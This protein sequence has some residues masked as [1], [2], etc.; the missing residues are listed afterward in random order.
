MSSLTLPS[1]PFSDYSASALLV[2]AAPAPVPRVTRGWPEGGPRVAQPARGAA[3]WTPPV[4][5]CPA[6]RHSSTPLQYATPVSSTAANW[7]RSSP[8]GFPSPGTLSRVARFCAYLHLVYGDFVFH[9]WC[10]ILM[11]LD[12]LVTGHYGVVMLPF[13]LCGRGQIRTPPEGR[14]APGN[15]YRTRLVTTVASHVTLLDRHEGAN[16]HL[17]AAVHGAQLPASLAK[18]QP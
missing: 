8:D 5:A 3:V 7:R 12:C 9:P 13:W 17:D 6:P 14:Q 10:R 4:P 18:R 16:T 2:A 1:P 15:P 11:W